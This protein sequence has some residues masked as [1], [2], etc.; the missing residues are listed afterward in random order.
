M[1]RSPQKHLP[2]FITLMNLFAGF[3]S[4]IYS[5]QGDYMLAGWLIVIAAVLDAVDGKIARLVKSTSDF[6]GELDSLADVSS[7]GFA[8]AVLMYQTYF[9]SW[10]FAGI[11]VSFL[12]LAAGGLRL[13][14]FNAEISDHAVKDPFFKGLPIPSSAIVMT[15][16]VMFDKAVFESF[17][18]P[19][20]LLAIAISACLLMISKIRYD[21]P[22]VFTFRDTRDSVKSLIVLVTLPVFIIYPYQTLFPFMSFF[23]ITG[24]LRAVTG[25]F[26]KTENQANPAA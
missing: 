22:P 25:L 9:Y 4:V 1:S 24:V 15:S 20:L 8:P 26:R 2:S 16:F 7:F 17:V 12:P 14:R 3:L 21:A 11:L 6:G 13:A 23:A 5:I 10:E 18:H 19:Y